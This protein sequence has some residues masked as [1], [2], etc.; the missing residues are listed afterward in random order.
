[1]QISSSTI[2]ASGLLSQKTHLNADKTPITV[3][4]S[5]ANNR[6]A[7]AVLCA[8]SILRFHPN[9]RFIV[10]LSD[11]AKNKETLLSFLPEHSEIVE[12][13]DLGIPNFKKF[14]FRYTIAELCSNVKTFGITY[15][16]KHYSSKKLLY[17]DGDFLFFGPAQE[18]LQALESHWIALTPQRLKPTQPHSQPKEA[19][20]HLHGLFNAGFLAM[21]SDVPTVYQWN[22]WWQE[23]L[24]QDGHQ[25]PHSG[26]WGDQ[27][28]LDQ[29]PIL[30][31]GVCVFNHPGYNI[32]HW[33]TDERICD[34]NLLRPTANGQ[35]V[36]CVHL[37]QVGL[38]A[39]EDFL[40]SYSFFDL[41]RA[42]FSREIGP[43]IK[44]Y[45][46]ALQVLLNEPGMPA[47]NEIPAYSLFENGDQISDRHRT[48]Y[49]HQK[50]KF[51]GDDPF[52][53]RPEDF[54]ETFKEL[55]ITN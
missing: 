20:I 13:K 5:S 52:E 55:A 47:L 10:I 16:L 38:T 44:P 43:I 48:L 27:K 22:M 29:L 37:S 25:W 28:W 50:A 19:R 54:L 14:A 33:N 51:G 11:V 39:G 30:F 46:E 21:R 1:M 12:I 41:F 49:I 15:A 4:I 40:N 36:C 6:F 18:A 53:L 9:A 26:Y 34:F 31:S 3:V 8:R 35:S 24:L 42:D 7:Q 32:A 45:R 2:K 23:R 17:V